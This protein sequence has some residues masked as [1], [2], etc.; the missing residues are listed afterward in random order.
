VRR[1]RTVP[2]EAVPSDNTA[3]S[4]RNKAVS[5]IDVD[6]EKLPQVHRAQVGADI[7]WATWDQPANALVET[8]EAWTISMD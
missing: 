2:Q 4:G 6:T 3:W 5:P 8:Q 1:S 7:F